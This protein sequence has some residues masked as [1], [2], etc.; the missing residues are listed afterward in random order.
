MRYGEIIFLDVEDV[1][2]AHDAALDCGGGLPG[3][4]DSGL[5]TSATMAPQAGYYRSLAQLAA[6]YVYGIAKNH[7]YLDANKRTAT[8]V[9]LTFLGANGFDVTLGPEWVDIMEG[10]AD[11]TVSRDRLTAEIARL[12]GGDVQVDP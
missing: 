1:D 7:G 11:D 9:M 6:A 5:I 8:L 3:V 2:A 4:R 10:V 12:I